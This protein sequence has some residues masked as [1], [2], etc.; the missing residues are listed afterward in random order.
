MSLEEGGATHRGADV[1]LR[2]SKKTAVT[3]AYGK[4]EQEV[5]PYVE[6]SL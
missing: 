6:G 4:G 3:A 5:E 2:E 1:G